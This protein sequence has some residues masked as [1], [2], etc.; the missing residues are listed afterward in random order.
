MTR[1]A[2]LDFDALLAPISDSQPCGSDRD[3]G[4]NETLGIAFSE[5]L[6]LAVTA[7]KI[8]TRRY[9]LAVMPREVREDMLRHSQG[10][11]DG[12]AADPRWERIAELAVEIL[13]KHSKDTRVLV[14]LIDSMT[15]LHGLA[16]LCDALK[17]GTLL[18]D[19]YKLALFPL[20]VPGAEA[21]YCVELISKICESESY[22]IKS[23]LHQIDILPRSPGLNWRSH[24]AATA[25]EG[26][27]AKE[28]EKH[29]Q[30]GELT[31]DHFNS[32]LKL[33]T[34]SEDLTE[35]DHQ[36]TEAIDQAKSF[37]A[38][39]TQ[40]SNNIVGIGRIL[41][42]LAQLQRW[43]RGLIEDRLAVVAASAPLE[44]ELIESVD[45][46]DSD[47]SGGS[48]TT[49]TG[50]SASIS[51]R[52]QAFQRLLQVATYFRTAEPHSPLSYALEQ[53]VRWGEM[54]LPDLLRD[55]VPDETVLSQVFRRMG[56]QE[57]KENSDS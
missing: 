3:S 51:N 19:R 32:E 36:V 28:R 24:I 25:L 4:E 23:V 15:R 37:D 47:E 12:P 6:S 7:R 50:A 33:I 13:T 21:Y 52:Q 56:I 53:A 38:Q 26:R 10:Q 16:G 39:L 45:A 54:P 34:K 35:F 8:E 57:N 30:D 40:L 5:L 27:P 55:L 2:L 1:T 17:A 22:N 49:S 14:W 41:E 11:S 9:D 44:T 43:Y 18:L 48:N 29:V 31:L 20:P 46:H 42:D